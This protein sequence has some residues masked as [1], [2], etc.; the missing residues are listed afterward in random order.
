MISETNYK[1][2][3][4][5][6]AVMLVMAPMAVIAFAQLSGLGIGKDRRH[7]R[8][9]VEPVLTG[10]GFALDG[11][12][13]HVLDIN[14]IKI[15]NISPGFIRSLCSQNKNREGIMKASSYPRIL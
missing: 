11:D 13:H 8:L 9:F 4:L 10:H 2:A 1:I 12:Q 14:A 7:A 15:S 3:I 5:F 6:A